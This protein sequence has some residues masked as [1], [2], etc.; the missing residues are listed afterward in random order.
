MFQLSK[1]KWENLKS[2]FVISSWGG[3]RH[4]P[5]AFTEQGVAMLSSVLRS[6][7]AVAVNVE[8][9]RAFVR[10]RRLMIEHAD[11]ATR[12]DRLERECETLV[13][14]AEA[15]VPPRGNVGGAVAPGR[16]PTGERHRSSRREVRPPERYGPPADESKDLLS[17]AC[18]TRNIP[19]VR[20]GMA[21]EVR[22]VR[23]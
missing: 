4:P 5:Y 1:S 18:F 12:L 3:Q 10:L 9:M 22:H 16:I 15:A 11:L 8:I 19:G 14:G 6:T 17:A 2:Q 23:A 13:G 20:A 21:D 7:R